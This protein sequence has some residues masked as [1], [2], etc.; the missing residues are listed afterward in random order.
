MRKHQCA[1]PHL[2][3]KKNKYKHKEKWAAVIP[4][5]Y[6]DWPPARVWTRQDKESKHVCFHTKSSC[7]F[8]LNRRPWWPGSQQQQR[9]LLHCPL[10]GGGCGQSRRWNVSD[11]GR[12]DSIL[13]GWRLHPWHLLKTDPVPFQTMTGQLWPSRVLM[14]QTQHEPRC[15]LLHH[16]VDKG[17]CESNSRCCLSALIT[18]LFYASQPWENMW[19]TIHYTHL[20]LKDKDKKKNSSS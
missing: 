19:K 7:I 4:G 9:H 1:F 6:Q 3:H 20:G 15:Q 10:W 18:A 8:L 5:L 17:S 2:G 13:V 16:P 11:S 12:W 14:N